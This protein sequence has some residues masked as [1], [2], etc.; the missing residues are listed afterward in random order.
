MSEKII[1]KLNKHLANKTFCFLFPS[2]ARTIKIAIARLQW[3]EN[4]Q[5]KITEA[6]QND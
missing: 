6:L 1:N 5:N 4:Q 3:L 2:I